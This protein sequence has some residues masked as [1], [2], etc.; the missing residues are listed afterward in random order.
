MTTFYYIQE[1]IL[2]SNIEFY[3]RTENKKLNIYWINILVY[4]YNVVHVKLIS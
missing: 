1:I 4:N 2:Y 3:I